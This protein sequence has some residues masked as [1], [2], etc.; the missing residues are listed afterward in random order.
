MIGWSVMLNF[1]T[2]GALRLRE[3]GARHVD[4]PLHIL[5][6]EVGV[7]ALLE[8]QTMQAGSRPPSSRCDL[9][10]PEVLATA[11]SIGLVTR[12]S[13]FPGAGPRV[14]DADRDD[15]DLD[16]G[17]EVHRH[18]A[19]RRPRPPIMMARIAMSITS[20]RRMER[21]VSHMVACLLSL[22]WVLTGHRLS[23]RRVAAIGR[24]G[25]FGD[26]KKGPPFVRSPSTV[27]VVGSHDE[28]CRTATDPRWQKG[29]EAGPEARRGGE[30]RG[31]PGGW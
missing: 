10:R 31:P 20:G 25:D 13:T 24:R 16:A 30:V 14:G 26:K 22:S 19:G 3:A 9:F 8:L 2:A 11:S 21:D 1:M 23:D 27:V 17:H 5:G 6:D 28:C 4:P 18:G 15:R 12:D 29:R 7:H